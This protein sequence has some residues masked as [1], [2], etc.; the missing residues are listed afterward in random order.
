MIQLSSI[1]SIFS[2]LVF[3]FFINAV[4]AQKEPKLANVQ[5]AFLS[6]VHLQDLFGKFSDTDYRG[7]LNPKTT[8]N[9]NF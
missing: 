6:D 9:Q 4:I 1:K 5:V 8:F 7:I 3:F 2:S